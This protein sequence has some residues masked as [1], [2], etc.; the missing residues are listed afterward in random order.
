M[1]VEIEIIFE[2][3]SELAEYEALN[4]GRRIDVIVH[5][6]EKKYKLYVIHIK[7]LQQ[8]FESEIEDNGYYFTDPLTI[9]VNDMEKEVIKKTIMN[10]YKDKYFDVIDRRGFD[11]WLNK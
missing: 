7:R 3:E 1:K 6:G 4:K 9:I 8:D 2:D 5:I 11:F 10:L